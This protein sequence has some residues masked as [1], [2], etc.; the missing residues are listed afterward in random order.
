MIK[1]WVLFLSRGRYRC[2][3]T[4]RRVQWNTRDSGRKSFTG[5]QGTSHRHLYV[6]TPSLGYGQHGAQPSRAHHKTTCYGLKWRELNI[7][8]NQFDPYAS[9]SN[10]YGRFIPLYMSCQT[11]KL[12]SLEYPNQT[13]AISGT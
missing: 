10:S 4:E 9:T 6:Q 1:M 12:P 3:S 5:V 7:S 2:R 11:H 8:R 13:Q